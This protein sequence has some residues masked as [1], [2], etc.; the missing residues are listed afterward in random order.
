MNAG[1]VVGSERHIMA[2]SKLGCLAIAR[3][4][5]VAVLCMLPSRTAVNLQPPSSVVFGAQHMRMLEATHAR[6]PQRAPTMPGMPPAKPIIE[7]MELPQTREVDDRKDNN[8]RKGTQQRGYIHITRAA[9]HSHARS[10]YILRFQCVCASSS[11]CVPAGVG[12]R[13]RTRQSRR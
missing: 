10:Y 3:L 12:Q 11:C 9:T 1:G 4:C 2:A 5:G 7:K 6:I 8:A 13:R